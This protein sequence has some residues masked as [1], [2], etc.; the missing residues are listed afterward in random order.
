VLLLKAG[1]NA[2]AVASTFGVSRAML[3]RWQQNYAREGVAGLETKNTTG[4][5][6]RLDATQMAKLY[7]WIVSCNPWQLQF[8]SGLWTRK[9]IR[10]LI[11]SEFG[12]ELSEVQI[13][14]LLEKMGLS[15]PRP[16]HRASR[17]DPELVREWRRAVY[18]GIRRL[19]AA[20]KASVFFAGETRIRTDY[21]SGTARA[22]ANRERPA[23]EARHSPPVRMMSA[24]STRG[25]LHFRVYQ[26]QMNSV[27][28][29]EF[30]KALL[31]NVP[32]KVFLILNGNRIQLTKK[33]SQF[34]ENGTN[35]RLRI[36][37]L[38][39]SSPRLNPG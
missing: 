18:P 12:V 33:V 20:E 3:Y 17:T 35:A 9:I 4:P 36:F 31:S 14:R 16:L 2:D 32:G 37:F 15:P 26:G 23:A 5:A 38:P 30:L 8:D 11:Q 27:R 34:A 6:P 21:F 29:I 39:S 1:T 22:P 24:T 25:E 19:A 28:F 7:A 10:E 13:G